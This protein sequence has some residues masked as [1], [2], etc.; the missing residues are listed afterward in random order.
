MARCVTS[1]IIIEDEMLKALQRIYSLFIKPNPPRKRNGGKSRG[2]SLVEVAIAFPVFIMLLSGV[3]EFGFILNYYLSLLDATR[4]TARFF[5]NQDPFLPD[6]V[7]DNQNFY[8]QTALDVQKTLDPKISDA[9]YVG[10][11]IVLDPAHDDV[12]VSVYGADY[13]A[14]GNRVVLSRDAGPYYLFPP[15]D[16]AA[17]QRTEPHYLSIFTTQDILNTRVC[18]APNAGLL[19]VE[20]HYNYHQVLGLPWMTAVISNPLHLRAYTIMPIRAG[21]PVLPATPVATQV[22]P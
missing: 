6:G 5:S 22:C 2:Q 21:E 15:A 13:I 10:R 7:T 11:R 20:V 4:D 16:D 1:V 18:G 3:I 8:Y 12:I 17:N 19:V 14:S 9:N